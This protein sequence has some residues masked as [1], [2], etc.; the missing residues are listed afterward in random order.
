LCFLDTFV[1]DYTHT[2]THTH[3]H[4][5]SFLVKVIVNFIRKRIYFL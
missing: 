2:H 4:T 3:T 1:E 5:C